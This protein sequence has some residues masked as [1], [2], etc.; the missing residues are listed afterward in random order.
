MKTPRV[1]RRRTHCAQEPEGPPTTQ[2]HWPGRCR[3]VLLSFQ[4]NQ[5]TFFSLWLKNET[6]TKQ[7]LTSRKCLFLVSF[8]NTAKGFYIVVFILRTIETE[9]VW[10]FCPLHVKSHCHHHR[11]CHMIALT[12]T[13]KWSDHMTKWFAL[14]CSFWCKK[15]TNPPSPLKNYVNLTAVL[16]RG[17]LDNVPSTKIW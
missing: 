8:N 11:C 16:E 3:S 15:E 13:T 9:K 12:P 2:A 10:T 4:A 1:E 7:F 14:L 5:C 17:P 6:K